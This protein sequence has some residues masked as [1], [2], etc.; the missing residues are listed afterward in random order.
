M[1]GLPAPRAILFDWDNTLVDNWRCVQAALNV[2]RA[3]FQ[4]PPLDLAQTLANARLSARDSFPRMFGADW[5]RAKAIFYDAF[6]REHLNGLVALDGADRLLD[7]LRNNG[8]PL[9]VVSNKRGAFLRREVTHLGWDGRFGILVGAGDAARD[10]PDPAPALMALGSLGIEA[11]P[12]V[13]FVGDTDIDLRTGLAAGCTPIL[14][15]T[16]DLDEALM[17]DCQPS[18]RVSGL[19]RLLDLVEAVYRP[20]S[21]ASSKRG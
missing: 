5:Q 4:M 10:K 7:R 17:L 18:A 19:D 16:S 6:E 3:E 2:A 15:E 8:V 1:S 11:G 14:V 9:A 20:I 12:G 21:G 13:W